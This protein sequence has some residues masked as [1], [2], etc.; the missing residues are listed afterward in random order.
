MVIDNKD[1]FP[2][3]LRKEPEETAV[4]CLIEAICTERKL[5]SP[6]K[7]MNCTFAIFTLLQLAM[8]TSY[9]RMVTY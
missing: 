4:I 2:R 3:H 7:Q 1:L 5:A 8:K 6:L 9:T